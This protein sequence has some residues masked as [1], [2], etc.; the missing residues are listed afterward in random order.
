MLLVLSIFFQ[1]SQIQSS[2]KHRENR[3]QAVLHLQFLLSI[4]LSLGAFPCC[5]T[6]SVFIFS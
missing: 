2:H 4:T 1:V 5:Y 6:V 3:L